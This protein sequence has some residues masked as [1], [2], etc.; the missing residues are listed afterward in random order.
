MQAG[1]VQEASNHHDQLIAAFDQ[2]DQEKAVEI[3]LEH[4]QLSRVE[5]DKYIHPDPLAL[6]ALLTG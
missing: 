4:W 1:K 2:H 6:D 3:T 5:M